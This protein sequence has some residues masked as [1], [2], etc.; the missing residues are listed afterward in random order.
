MSISLSADLTAF[1][2]RHAASLDE[3]ATHAD[4]LVPALGASGLLA[5]G[6]PAVHGGSGSALSFGVRAIAAVAEHSLAA[7]FVAW[8][9]RAFIEYLVR[10][11]NAGLRERW[12]P[13]LLTGRIA[14]ATGLS[15]AMKF[16]SG[17][18]SLGLS[19]SPRASADAPGALSLSGSVPWAANLRPAAFLVAVAVARDDGGA[20]FVAALPST[21]AG[22]QRSADLDLIGLRG[23]RTASL[24]L[25]DLPLDDED[26]IAVDARSWL[27]AVRPAFLGLQ[28]GLSIGL[29]RACLEAAREHGVNAKAVLGEPIAALERSLIDTEATLLA[30]LD[31][32][33]FAAAPAA[34]FELRIRLAGIVLEAAQLELQAGGGRA[35]HRDQPLGFARR[36]REAAFIPIVTP[37]LSQL[38]GELLRHRERSLLAAAA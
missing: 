12:L 10:S 24:A 38:R 2:Q 26:L 35:Y 18:E 7:A 19:A 9:Q 30:G 4:A 23:T 8:G 20:P 37:S 17:I 36:W 22:L 28:C 13:D 31:D 11:R 33:R 21:R 16:L 34:L 3:S 14:G 27:P 1:L 6:V 15:N 32:G 29:A 5:E 25:R